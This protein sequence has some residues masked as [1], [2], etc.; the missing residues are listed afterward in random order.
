MLCVAPGVLALL[1]RWCCRNP[2]GSSGRGGVAE[3]LSA[4]DSFLVGQD[5]AEVDN[6]NRQRFVAP[7]AV[8][9]A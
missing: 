4:R 9:R 6:E 3:S 2:T 7:K 1:L 8:A 5:G